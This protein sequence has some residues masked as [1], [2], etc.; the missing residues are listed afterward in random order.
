MQII[1]WPNGSQLWPRLRMSWQWPNV[2][3]FAPP[4]ALWERNT[5]ES[6]VDNNKEPDVTGIPHTLHPAIWIWHTAWQLLR[7]RLQ[8]RI[9]C[10]GGWSAWWLCDDDACPLCAFDVCFINQFG[11]RL[12]RGQRWQGRNRAESGAKGA[13]GHSQVH[14][15]CRRNFPQINNFCEQQKKGQSQKATSHTHTLT[16]THTASRILILN[17]HKRLDTKKKSNKCQSRV[18]QL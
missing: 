10:L 6:Q 14:S 5:F 17:S 4:P 9:L 16:N 2:D 15:R 11:L 3:C 7:L 18:N 12:E 8:V 13:A 1:C